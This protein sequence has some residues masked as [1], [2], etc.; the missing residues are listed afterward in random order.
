VSGDA[1]LGGQNSIVVEDVTGALD[2]SAHR[3]FII[4]Q[5]HSVQ[6]C[7]KSAVSGAQA[8]KLD[9]QSII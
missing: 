6:V 7:V 2:V 9:R 8:V 5:S 4:S 3:V 1:A